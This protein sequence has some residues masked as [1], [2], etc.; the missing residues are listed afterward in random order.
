[1]KIPVFEII[2]RPALTLTLSAGAREQRA[3]VS[4]IANARRCR[5]ADVLL[6]TDWNRWNQ[7]RHER[8]G[9]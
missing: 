3:G 7:T 2:M 9:N 5:T 1:M 6:A 8:T 4:N